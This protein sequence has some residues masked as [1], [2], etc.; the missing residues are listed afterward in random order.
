MEV[1]AMQNN[2]R[3]GIEIDDSLAFLN[4]IFEVTKANALGQS[5]IALEV[6]AQDFNEHHA[7]Y[8]SLTRHIP[9]TTRTI[10]AITS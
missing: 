6:S 9:G 2:T 5:S 3:Q 4:H 7:I 8:D 1:A 10:V